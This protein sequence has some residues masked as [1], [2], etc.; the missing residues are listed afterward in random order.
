M[1]TLPSA[2]ASWPVLPTGALPRTETR[3][4]K[5]V[6]VFGRDE[7]RPLPKSRRDLHQALG[8]LYDDQSRLV[9]T[10]FCV[11]PDIVATAAHCVH[12]TA[13]QPSPRL[14]HMTFRRSIADTRNPARIAGAA[15]RNATQ[16]VMSGSMS[17][18][19]RPPI[20]ATRDWALLRLERPACRSSTLK[21]ADRTTA[22]VIDLSQADRVYQVAFHRDF[23][24]WQ[25]AIGR[26]CKIARSFE[27]ADWETIDRDFEDAGNLVLHVC[28]TGG[29]SSGSPLLIDGPDGPEV[30]AINVG[31]YVLSRVLMNDD[32]I[33]KR[34]GS[35]TIAN[36]ALNAAII[37]RVLPSLARAE[38]LASHTAITELQQELARHGF[39][40]GRI[41]GI[42]GRETRTAIETFEAA[43]RLPLTGLASRALLLQLRHATSAARSTNETSRLQAAR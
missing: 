11:A 33:V 35:D 27:H 28:D 6:A 9:C 36:T 23:A 20:D 2:G 5:N 15:S 13:G 25:L 42:Y 26:P 40:R 3:L 10:A 29:A 30:V 18:K 17:L 37:K 4:A 19:V 1:L 21:L 8:L 7:R 39:L 16:H 43:R 22:E 38:I 24:D 14:N 12:G 41:D 34:F 32:K 31:T